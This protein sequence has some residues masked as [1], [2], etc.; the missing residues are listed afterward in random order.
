MAG[1]GPGFDSDPTDELPLPRLSWLPVA[2]D[3]LS[4]V[5]I[6]IVVAFCREKQEHDA[7]GVKQKK[8]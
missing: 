4:G 1:V 2:L 3:K 6:I 5:I 8:Y 7:S